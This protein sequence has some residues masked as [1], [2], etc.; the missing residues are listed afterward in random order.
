MYRL[1]IFL[2]IILLTASPA[3]AEE[4]LFNSI[5]AIKGEAARIGEE[6]VQVIT[7]PVDRDNLMGTLA[8]AGAVG[9]VYVFD[10]DIRTKVLGVKGRTLDRFTDAGSLVGSPY[11]HLGVAA[12]VY[13]GA[14]LAESKK[15]RSL[16]EMLGESLILAD[17]ATLLLKESI[18][19]GR[20]YVGAGKSE[21]KPFSFDSDSD[22][23]PSMHTASSF[24]MA[25]VVARTTD[26]VP[27]KL[28]SYSAAAFVGFSR[29]YEDQ[30]WASDVLIGAVIGEVCGRVVTNYHAA[31]GMS[32]LTIAPAAVNNGAALF[33]TGKF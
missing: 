11:L 33:L 31:M 18:G 9:L 22:A 10:D 24:A 27:V 6:A 30:H 19:R 28:L 32:R 7:T 15:Y 25:S 5:P 1:L 16:G 8:I 17:A 3:V 26:S 23:M 4:H 14:V 13:G 2:M 12:A 20:P 29:I 21:Y